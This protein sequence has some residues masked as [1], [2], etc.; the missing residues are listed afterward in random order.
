[1]SVDRDTIISVTQMLLGSL[2]KSRK[3][4]G[5]DVNLIRQQVAAAV[6]LV[7]AADADVEE[8]TAELARRFDVFVQRA[9]I[10]VEDDNHRRWARDADRSSWRFWP[11]CRT[12]LQTQLPEP[13]VERLDED[14][15]RILELL[16]DPA[17]P[18]PWDRRGLVVGDVQFGK[19]SNYAAL[20]C[21]AADAGYK[22]IIVLAGI[23]ESLRMQT[24][25]RMDDAFLGFRT[26]ASRA[27]TGVGLI[28]PS[29]AAVA[30]TAR[31]QKGDF[32]K[33]V[34]DQLIVPFDIGPP[35]MLVV[36]K[37]AM[38]LRNLHAWL[39]RIARTPDGSGRRLITGAPALIIDDES[40]NAS[41][42]TGEQNFDAAGQP[43]LTHKPT[44]I[45]GLIRK[46]LSTFERRSYV[47]YTATPFANIFIH[48]EGQTTET[49]AELFPKNFIVNLHPP[50]NYFGPLRAFGLEGDRDTRPSARLLRLIDE[51]PED[52]A[53]L[54]DW[55]P[56]KHKQ[57]IE[58]GPI[59]ASLRRAMLS[60]L[61]ACTV[62]KLRGQETEHNSM[63][64]HVTRYTRVQAIVHEQIEDALVK[65]KRRLRFG[66]ETAGDSVK[67]ELRRLWDQDFVPTTNALREADEPD[68]GDLP[69]W[70]RVEAS[71]ADVAHGVRVKQINGL[72]QDVLDYDS[73][74]E[75]GIDVIVV[76]GDKLSRGLTLPGL[77]ISYFNRQTDMY[78]T[79]LQMG[80]W[81]GYR[82][83]YLDLCRL[84]TSRTLE[85]A[86]EHIAFASDLL[87][88]DFDYMVQIG[89][90]PVDYGLKVVAHRV[91]SATSSN[92]R[93]HAR[94]IVLY[95][96][97][98]G[99]VS[100]VKSFSLDTAILGHNKNDLDLLVHALQA[101]QGPPSSSPSSRS[102]PGSYLW[103]DVPW[104]SVK[105]FLDA[106]RAQATSTRARPDLWVRYVD[107]TIAAIGELRSWNVALIGGDQA[108]V[109]I[110]GLEVR[111]RERMQDTDLVADP[112]SYRIKRLVTT[113]DAAID[114]DD[115]TWNS[116]LVLDPEHR[117]SGR[118]R[119]EP[120]AHAICSIRERLQ[121]NPLLLVYLPKAE[122]VTT[123]HPIVGLAVAFP[124]S[125]R[126]IRDEVVYTVNTVYQ[127]G[128]QE[129]EE[130]ITLEEFEAA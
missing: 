96:S 107:R 22:M 94:D 87:R 82:T 84:Y 93:R 59:P 91:L 58:P 54:T 19:T 35:I 21:K 31:S 128:H 4:D 129:D 88:R 78:D 118:L 16:G 119:T 66:D 26:D 99:G 45:N 23:H 104:A 15:D 62:R 72:A 12:Y 98:A 90:R 71:L 17:E 3:A 76:G 81:F 47:G 103:R 34:A 11:R 57:G 121:L 95:R 64:V 63:L 36:K 100:E 127:A 109:S 69:D 113:R 126:A 105:T 61:L 70:S 42:D 79:L 55:V 130:D 111:Q 41:V 67:V 73:H 1:M 48:H 102:Y 51:Q 7:G 125:D 33:I 8:I 74:R 52:R 38:M 49:G 40:D 13:V 65:I 114:L 108:P 106:Y 68:I 75:T 120:T 39:E 24:Q 6:Q 56:G 116:A 85:Q 50:S 27:L 110:E 43:D 86:F 37:N 25:I 122:D 32:N 124:G 97:Y 117:V 115:P 80:R 112:S 5:L 89:A 46:I 92:K 44:T 101:D 9:A 77:T 28:D 10:L 60:F 123:Q 30:A 53:Q 20:A 14:T 18:T 83:G 2:I 29:V